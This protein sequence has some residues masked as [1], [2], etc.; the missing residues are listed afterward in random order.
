MQIPAE[1]RRNV[2]RDLKLEVAE[3]EKDRGKSGERASR[4]LVQLAAERD[5][6]LRAYYAEAIP[7]ETLKLEQ[8]RIDDEVDAAE[9]EITLSGTRL[10]AAKDLIELCLERLSDCARAYKEAVPADRRKWNHA[11]FEKVFVKDGRVMG[12]EIKEPFATIMAKGSSKGSSPPSSSK[13]PQVD[14]TERYSNLIDELE[15]LPKRRNTRP[16]KPRAHSFSIGLTNS[17]PASG[18]SARF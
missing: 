13:N 10:V 14:L 15:G 3:R 5:K 8:Q 2:E 11:L 7:V 17:T 6:L 9:G 4:R 1:V 16:N 12:A 18:S